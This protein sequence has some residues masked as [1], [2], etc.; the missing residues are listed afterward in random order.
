MKKHVAITRSSFRSVVAEFKQNI[1]LAKA[2]VAELKQAVADADLDLARRGKAY[3]DKVIGDLMAR[4]LAGFATGALV[5]AAC[6]AAYVGVPLVSIPAIIS[7]GGII[8]GNNDDGRGVGRQKSKHTKGDEH[9]LD[10]TKD[11]DEEEGQEEK[12]G[13]VQDDPD[14]TQTNPK[15]CSPQIERRV[16]AAQETW[17]D[18]SVYVCSAKDMIAATT[19]GKALFNKMSLTELSTLVAIAQTAIVAMERT[20][21]AIEAVQAPLNNLVGSIDRLAD[22]LADIDTARVPHNGEMDPLKRIPFSAQ[23][24]AEVESKWREIGE[25]CEVWLDIFNAQGISPVTPAM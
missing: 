24:V 12:Q 22:I 25:L 19:I 14:D 15:E 13:V 5:A 23:D 7:A 21:M 2:N 1:E 11:D 3:R 18:L 17:K 16:E 8:F 6:A 20:V 4:C 9:G 10:K